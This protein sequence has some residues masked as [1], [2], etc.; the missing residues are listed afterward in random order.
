MDIE[1][2]ITEDGRRFFRIDLGDQLT[3]AEAI[4]IVQ[5]L[6]ESLKEDDK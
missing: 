2:E 5:D 1:L 6:M 3:D 4:E